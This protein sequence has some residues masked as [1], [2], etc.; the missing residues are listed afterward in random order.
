[1]SNTLIK[2][3]PR[4]NAPEL[5]ALKTFQMILDKAEPIDTEHGVG[6]IWEETFVPIRFSRIQKLK[7]QIKELLTSLETAAEEVGID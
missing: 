5:E 7:A 1:M 3:R 2:P 6:K 4:A